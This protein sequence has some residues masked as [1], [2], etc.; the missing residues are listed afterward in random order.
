MPD[1]EVGM[2]LQIVLRILHF[3]LRIYYIT[4]YFIIIT[5]TSQGDAT[6]RVFPVASRRVAFG[7]FLA[8][9]VASR[10]VASRRFRCV[11]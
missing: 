1:F 11:S 3:T 2:L 6:R 7:V 8:Y 10:R 4:H 9:L 5:Y